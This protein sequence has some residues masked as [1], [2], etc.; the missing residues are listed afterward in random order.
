MRP[1]SYSTYLG[2]LGSLFERVSELLYLEMCRSSVACSYADW[3]CSEW[4]ASH[5]TR[6]DSRT[7]FLGNG[8]GQGTETPL[9]VP[10]LTFASH[11]LLIP[12]Q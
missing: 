12:L 6:L 5:L 7:E 10:V 8:T 4:K 3:D 9:A 11:S 1:V 2:V